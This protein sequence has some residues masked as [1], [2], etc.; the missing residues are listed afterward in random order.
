MPMSVWNV[1]QHDNIIDTVFYSQG[2]S[3][4]Y[5]RRSLIAHDGYPD[6]ITVELS[7]TITTEADAD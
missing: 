6:D 1:V 2:L 4:D 5:V 7:H 3:E